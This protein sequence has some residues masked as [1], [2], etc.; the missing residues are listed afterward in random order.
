MNVHLKP[1]V[2]KYILIVS[3]YLV[4]HLWFEAYTAVRQVVSFSD[5]KIKDIIQEQLDDFN[6]H[7]YK[8]KLQNFVSIS[9]I[10]C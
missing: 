10:L 7:T 4:T 5:L 3:V 8:L 6:M 2:A 1:P 9:D